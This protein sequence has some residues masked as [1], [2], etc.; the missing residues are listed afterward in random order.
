MQDTVEYN[1]A[2]CGEP[3]MTFVDFSAGMQQSYVEDCQVCCQPNVLYIQIDED[4]L[5][6]EISSEPES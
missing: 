4:T 6:I 5:D 1:C 3:N 2:F